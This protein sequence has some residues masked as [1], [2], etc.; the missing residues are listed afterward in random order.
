VIVSVAGRTEMKT[1]TFQRIYGLGGWKT[2]NYLRRCR[3][4]DGT[5]RAANETI[6]DALDMTLYQVEWHIRQLAKGGVI[7]I[8]EY[9]GPRSAVR[10]ILGDFREGQITLPAHA[11]KQTMKMP[12]RGGARRGAGRPRKDS[13]PRPFSRNQSHDP[14]NQSHDPLEIKATT[15]G[16]VKRPKRAVSKR[17]KA[18]ERSLVKDHLK[19]EPETESLLRKDL[20]HPALRTG[21]SEKA[22]PSSDRA[23]RGELAEVIPLRPPKARSPSVAEEREPPRQPDNRLL[24]VTKVPSP[25]RFEPDASDDEI[26][27][28]LATLYKSV[29]IATF[30]KKGADWG[31]ISPKGIFAK[32]NRDMLLKCGQLLQHYDIAPASWVAW[33]IDE[34]RD[35]AKKKKK[36]KNE[37]QPPFFFVFSSRMVH[38]GQEYFSLD[39]GGYMGGQRCPTPLSME[40]TRKFSQ[41]A[42]RRDLAARQLQRRGRTKDYGAPASM[43]DEDVDAFHTELD[44]KLEEEFF[45][46]GWESWYERARE[47]N[48]EYDR[49]IKKAIKLKRYV[50]RRRKSGLIAE[51]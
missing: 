44:A 40:V 36:L 4:S 3:N 15:Q 48:L 51:Y 31:M 49:L 27:D 6:A 38:Q 28:T 43:T 29:C 45:P 32:K 22:S 46:G 19:K 5:T 26:V 10:L 9:R 24:K 23:E 42:L 39:R 13:K 17:Q 20:S 21:P 50:W 2:W 34:W 7:E 1:K 12:R 37:N 41:Y 14:N 18:V 30:G 8:V 47:S 16:S 11:H 35:N 25:R 33:R